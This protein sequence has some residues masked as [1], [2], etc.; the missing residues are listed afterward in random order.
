[1]ASFILRMGSESSKSLTVRDD[2]QIEMEGAQLVHGEALDG[3]GHITS[4]RQTAEVLW[5]FSCAPFSPR[6]DRQDVARDVLNYACTRLG[7]PWPTGMASEAIRQIAA[8]S[9]EP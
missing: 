8:L 4:E 9:S 2:G 7:L 1:M 5:D 3:S 6:D